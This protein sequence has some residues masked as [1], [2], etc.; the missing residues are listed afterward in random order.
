LWTVVPSSMRDDP[1]P[2]AQPGHPCPG[3]HPPVDLPLGPDGRRQHRRNV[4][5][6]YRG[7]PAPER[8]AS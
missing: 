4:I 2:A 6:M 1:Q 8:L 5:I 3:A 7:P